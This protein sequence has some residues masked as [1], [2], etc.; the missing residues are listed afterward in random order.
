ME[1]LIEELCPDGVK[2]M[3]LGDLGEFIR[4]KRFVKTDIVPE[5]TPCIHYG[6]MYTHYKI[7]ATEA[8]SFLESNLAVKLRF[9]QHGDVVIVSAGETIEDI[10]NGVA[11]L[12]EE[13]VV[14]HDACFAF[15]HK[16]NP[17]FISYFFQTKFFRS[18]IKRHISSGKISS[19]NALG[20]SKAL[21]PIPPLSIQHEI[22]S[23]LDMFTHLEAE[24]KH[25]LEAELEARKK[26]YE[27]YRNELLNFEGKEVEWKTLGEVAYYSKD[28]IR[29]LSVN[30][31]N[32]V[33]VDNLLQNRKGK[34]ISNY[35]PEK[36]SLIGYQL[37]DILIGNIRPYLKKIWK[38]T[39]NGGTNGDVLVV[40]I[41][42]N[43]QN[44]LNSSYLYYH[45]ASDNFFEYNMQ[46]AKGAK[47]PRGNKAA[48]LKY[49]IPIP[50]NEEQLKIVAILD[51]FESRV[52][53][54]SVGLP[55]E[56]EARRKQYE[57]YREKLFTFK[58]HNTN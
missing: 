34:T 57:Y 1:K 58:P 45:L 5:G 4:G 44:K 20:L 37:N 6:E 53:D 42:P 35:V 52:N 14:I 32:Y 47:M 19:I 40:R 27:Y 25:E 30:P 13:N 7:W 43:F 49:K 28:R 21:M 33:G 51:N 36:G 15:R 22:V 3:K 2:L 10:G 54:I 29:A 11:W 46:F 38:S 41:N 48:L 39:S 17:K 8:K 12:G 24:L 55:A 23:I 31:T 16:M 9:A 50:F 18:Q 56:I 26:Q